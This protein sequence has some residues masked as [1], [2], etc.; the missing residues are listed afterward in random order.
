MA[1]TFFGLNIASS[2]LFAFQASANTIANNISNVQTAGYSRQVA[3]IQAGDALRVSA[4]YGTMGTGVVTTSI[5]QLRDSYYDTKY[6]RNQS[7]TGLYDRR[8]YFME[9]IESIYEDDDATT[10][11]AT[12]FSKM[13]NSLDTLKNNAGDTN[14]RNQFISDAQNLAIYFKFSTTNPAFL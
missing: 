10:G 13:F 12:I 1:S 6:W 4:K 9:Q 11:F 5:T 3:N 7:G 2:G 14:A 8:L